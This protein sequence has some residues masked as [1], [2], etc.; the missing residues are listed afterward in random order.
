MTDWTPLARGSG[1]EPRERESREARH[2]VLI[3]LLGAYADRELPPETASQIEAHLVGCARCRNELA[4]HQAVRLRLGVAPPV[5]APPALRERIVAAIAATP[6]PQAGSAPPPSRHV[7]AWKRHPVVL[8]MVVTIVTIAVAIGVNASFSDRD[9]GPIPNVTRLSVS[10]ASVP[11]LND[12]LADY[13]RVTA[14][15][16]PGRSRDLDLVRGAV[17]FPID[18]L[19]V[20]GVR[21]LAAWT[22]DLGGEAAA[23]LAYRWNDRIVLQYLVPEERFFRHRAIYATVSGNHLLVAS[24]NTQGLVAW[25]TPEGGAILIGDVAPEQLA[26]LTSADLLAKTARRGAK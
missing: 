8:A 20:N 21:L 15:D 25:P 9:V 4:V 19:R 22:T 1:E 12:A 3:E 5:A 13:R 2:Q 10:P 11:L 26:Q 14:G 17:P 16:L 18:P 7:A 6:I 23:V 24:A